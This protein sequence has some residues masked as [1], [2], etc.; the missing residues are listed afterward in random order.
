MYSPWPLS[1][2][3]WPMALC[4]FLPHESKSGA[5]LSYFKNFRLN[6]FPCL[7]CLS[8]PWTPTK[9]V[10]CRPGAISFTSFSDR[11]LS[12]ISPHSSCS[13]LWTLNIL[14]LI[15]IPLSAYFKYE[16]GNYKSRPVT[17]PRLYTWYFPPIPYSIICLRPKAYWLPSTLV[18]HFCLP[19]DCSHSVLP[20]LHPCSISMAH[21]G[22]SWGLMFNQGP[23]G[24]HAT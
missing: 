14:S 24:Y 20:S 15:P 17:S 18:C 6:A 1:S 23:R 12:L 16:K 2:S 19:S 7:E 22:L 21:Y 3:T 8:C 9:L 10:R 4:E 11:H 5:K 13:L